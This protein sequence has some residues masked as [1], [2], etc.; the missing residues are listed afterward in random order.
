MPDAFDI[1]SHVP[2][3]FCLDSAIF[4]FFTINVTIPLLILRVDVTQLGKR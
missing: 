2:T 4:T 1:Q 3:I